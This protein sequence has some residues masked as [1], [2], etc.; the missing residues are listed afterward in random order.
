MNTQLAD[1]IVLV[2]FG[3]IAYVV[4]GQLCIFA[5]ILLHWGWVRN[6][7][8]RFTHLSMML[9][10]AVEELFAVTCPLTIWENR[11]CGFDGDEGRAFI[12]RWVRQIIFY[13]LPDN[14]WPFV[15]G[16]LG[17]S[18]LVVWSIWKC[19]PRMRISRGTFVGLVHLFIG[20]IMAATAS[21]Q[22]HF[23]G[24]CFLAQS[25]LWFLAQL[26]DL[27]TRRV[28]FATMVSLLHAALAVACWATELLAPTYVQEE[29][30]PLW[31]A[32]A[33]FCVQALVW[34]GLQPAAGIWY[35]PS[36]TPASTD[37][38]D[39]HAIRAMD[40]RFAP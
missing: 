40:T 36:D 6:V 20:V 30:L 16:Y 10:V 27:P 5:G 13:D 3:W 32:G 2:H 1:A 34:Y 35:H 26:V 15:V 33:C 23:V 29:R 14:A 31:G 12:A 39:P 21:S 38:D 8:F 25:S 4:V 11:C 17:F 19:P 18:A 37:K 7:W 24:P 9:L 22:N 28:R